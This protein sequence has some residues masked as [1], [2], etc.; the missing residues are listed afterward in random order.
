MNDDFNKALWGM[1]IDSPDL[2]TAILNSMIDH[3]TSEAGRYSI[4]TGDIKVLA[5]EKLTDK[6]QNLLVQ[7]IHK[8]GE[9]KVK[10]LASIM[11]ELSA[12]LAIEE[13]SGKELNMA[14]KTLKDIDIT[15]L[16]TWSLIGWLSKVKY[17][18]RSKS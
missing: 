16:A 12:A 18:D 14:E 1:A 10:D 4:P 8:A 5:F 3:T 15:G 17:A 11:G 13:A 9:L 7:T 6:K 2:Q